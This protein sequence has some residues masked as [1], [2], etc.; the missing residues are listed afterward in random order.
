[1]DFHVGN[2]AFVYSQDGKIKY[3]KISNNLAGKIN[4]KSVGDLIDPKSQAYSVLYGNNQLGDYSSIDP[5][6]W[7]RKKP[8]SG[9]IAIKENSRANKNYRTVMTLL[10]VDFL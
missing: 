1:M 2:Y 3:S 4:L 9:R 6:V 5:S 7:I 8:T 10:K